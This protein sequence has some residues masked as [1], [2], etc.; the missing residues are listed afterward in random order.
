[1]GLIHMGGRVYDPVLGRFTSADPIVQA[2]SNSQSYNRYSYCINNP[3]SLTD[4]S[5]YSWL[6]NAFK[7]AW[8]WHKSVERKIHHWV[9]KNWRMIVVAVVVVVVAIVAPYAVAATAPLFGTTVVAGAT[10]A[11]AAATTA[12]TIAVG[13]VGGAVIGA[14]SSAIYGGSASDILK[15]ALIGGVTGAITAGLGSAGINFAAKAV[16]HG[17]VQGAASEVSGGDFVSGF[18][19]GAVGSISGGLCEGMSRTPSGILLRA[20]ISGVAGGTA[21]LVGGGSFANGAISAAFVSLLNDALHPKV[22]DPVDHS[23]PC[24]VCHGVSAGGF[25]G[26]VDSFSNLSAL[27]NSGPNAMR[28]YAALVLISKEIAIQVGLWLGTGSI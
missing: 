14:A 15:G 11:T 4:P 25:N 1:M 26:D 17:L 27:P 5:G 22:H 28:G 6:G 20:A 18:I 9:K 12:A 19:G 2:P 23:Q 21:A 24:I 7:K 16:L 10:V 8:N 3:L 13:A